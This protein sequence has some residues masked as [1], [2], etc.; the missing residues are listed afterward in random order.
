[1]KIAKSWKDKGALRNVNDFILTVHCHELF[2][3]LGVSRCYML[4]ESIFVNAWKK[5]LADILRT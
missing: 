1:M 4:N 3:L 2:R 5:G